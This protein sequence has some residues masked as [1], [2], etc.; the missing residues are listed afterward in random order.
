MD[1]DRRVN[2]YAQLNSGV[3]TKAEAVALGMSER[4]FRRRVESGQLVRMAAGT[5]ALP[6]LISNEES[7]LR[8][9][10]ASIGAV[11]SHESA[12][13]LHGIQGLNPKRWTVSVPIRRSNRFGPVTVHQLTDLDPDHVVAVNGIPTNDPARTAIDLSAVL[14]ERKLADVVDQIVNRRLAT[15]LALSERLEAIARKGKPGVVRLRKVLEPR[16]DNRVRIESSLETRLFDLV[17][18]SGLAIP[19]T[20][21]RPAWLKKRS[22]RVDVCYPDHRLVVEADSVRWHGSP[23]AFQEDRER[24]NRAQLAGWTILRFTWEDITKRQAYVVA[25]IRRIIERS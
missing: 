6:G 19:A 15:Y 8:A 2:L 22:G 9:A 12:A 10:V 5:Y 14:P 11:T 23:E 7:A 4:T 3:V 1:S 20:Q 21:F 17:V 16:I 24:D 18:S 25:S 13:R